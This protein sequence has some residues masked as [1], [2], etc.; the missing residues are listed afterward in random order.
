MTRWLHLAQMMQ[1]YITSQPEDFWV[2]SHGSRS[3]YGRSRMTLPYTLTQ[4]SLHTFRQSANSLDT[5]GELWLAWKN[6][7]LYIPN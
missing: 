3:S 5:L 1:R 4:R 6:L 7:R 2:G